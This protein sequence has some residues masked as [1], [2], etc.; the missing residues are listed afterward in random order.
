MLKIQIVSTLLEN[1]KNQ[2]EIAK[3]VERRFEN[4]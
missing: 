1:G 3:G 4:L 2:S